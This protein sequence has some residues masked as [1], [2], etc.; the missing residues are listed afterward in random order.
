M[1]SHQDGT[2]PQFTPEELASQEYQDNP[3]R[4]KL[5]TD[6]V[7]M[8]MGAGITCFQL[9]ALILLAGDKAR[10]Q[11]YSQLM[12][13]EYHKRPAWP[14]IKKAFARWEAIQKSKSE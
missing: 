6:L 4:L 14:K 9:P 10:F 5:V 12:G 8:V 11:R 1:T 2:P 3:E 13:Q 7:D